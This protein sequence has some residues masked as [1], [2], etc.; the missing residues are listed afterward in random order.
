MEILE[1]TKS[2]KV[3]K[4][5]RLMEMMLKNG[6]QDIVVKTANGKIVQYENTRKLKLK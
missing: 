2:E 5:V 1:I 3:D 4:G 6:Y